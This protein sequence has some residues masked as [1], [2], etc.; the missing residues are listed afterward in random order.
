LY[1]TSSIFF[2]L[3][4]LSIFQSPAV[5]DYLLV[6]TR[7]LI[8]PMIGHCIS[9]YINDFPTSGRDRIRP[10]TPKPVGASAATMVS[11]PRPP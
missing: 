7:L 3:Q 11:L 1:E 8:E 5:D 10:P 4:Q 6:P 9:G 2:N